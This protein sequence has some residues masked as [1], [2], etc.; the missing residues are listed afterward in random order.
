MFKARTH[1]ERNMCHLFPVA[2]GSSGGAPVL[3]SRMVG[4]RA[5]WKIWRAEIT[6]A[7]NKANRIKPIITRETRETSSWYFSRSCFESA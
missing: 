4:T 3:C 7:K 5:A 2:N 6:A 1:C